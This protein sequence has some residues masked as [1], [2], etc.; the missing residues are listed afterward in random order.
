[1]I[2]LS[3]KNFWPNFNYENNFFLLSMFKDI[4][5]EKEGE[6]LQEI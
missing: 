1:M 2:K 4:Y 6:L 3:I 5:G